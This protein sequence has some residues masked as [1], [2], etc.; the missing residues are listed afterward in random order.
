[1][2]AQSW[3]NFFISRIGNNTGNKDASV[4]STMWDQATANNAKLALLNNDTNTTLFAVGT[5]NKIII[6]HS[7]KNLGGTILNPANCYG[8]LIGNGRIATAVVVNKASLLSHV[9]IAIPRYES[10]IACLSKAEIEALPRPN[11]RAAHTFHGLTSFLLAPWLLEAISEANMHDPATLILAA[12]EAAVNSDHQFENDPGYITSTEEQLESFAQWAW[13][14][15]AGRIPRLMYIVEPNNKGLRLYGEQH[16]YS[17]IQSIQGAN[18]A[19]NVAPAAAASAVYAPQVAPG[20]PPPRAPPDVFNLLNA[21][22]SHQA[23]AMDQLNTAH[24]YNLVFQKEKETKKKDCF[25]KFHPSAKQLILFA[26]ASDSDNVPTEPEDTCERFMNATVQ[27][28]AEQELSM[29]FKTMGLGD[30]AYATG[31]TLNFNSGKFLYAVRNHSS[32]FSC[33]FGS[34]RHV[35]GQRRAVELSTDPPP[36]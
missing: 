27:G 3:H 33:F 28:V 7:V 13:G 30:L 2:A 10:I 14:A 18:A 6:V 5:N 23:D 17:T 34:Q 21:S 22:I 32:N 24:K 11:Q 8:P 1:M 36:D 35:S 16:H 26:L 15:V 29:Q 31:L 9:N 19:A 12:S 25:D 4:Y 20:P